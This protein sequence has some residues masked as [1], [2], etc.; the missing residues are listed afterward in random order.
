MYL[1]VVRLQRGDTLNSTKKKI[2]EAALNLFAEN[3]YSS[4]SIRDICKQVQIKESS[5]Y[6]HFKNKQAIFD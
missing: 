6:Y 4:V 3:G 2:S 5:V 1:T